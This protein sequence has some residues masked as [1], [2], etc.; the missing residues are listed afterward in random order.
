MLPTA[1]PGQVAGLADFGTRLKATF[2]NIPPGA[3]VFVSTSNVNNNA[4]AVSPPNPIGGIS[5]NSNSPGTYVGYAM[6]VN[7]ESTSDGNTPGFFP[8]VFATDNGPGN[9]SVPIAEVSV[10]NGTGT[11]VWEVMNTNPN[12]IESFQFAVY[13][14]YTANVAQNS[15]PPGTTTVNL[16]LA[17]TANSGVAADAGSPMP[18]FTSDANP[19]RPAFSIAACAPSSLNVAKSHTGNFTQGQA[20]AVYTVNV[21]NQAG[22]GPTSEW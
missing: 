8:A 6:L 10:T 14:T 2:N 12:T 15:P 21:S 5:G 19:A 22:A 4:L 18:R 1:N 17:A 20:N 16:S 3:H 13:V 9:G 11:A 7:G